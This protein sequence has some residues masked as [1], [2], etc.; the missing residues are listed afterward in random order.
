M[1]SAATSSAN[2]WG[3]GW[4]LLSISK[5]LISPLWGGKNAN[6]FSSQSGWKGEPS[7]WLTTPIS[8]WV[9]VLE[10][11]AFSKAEASVPPLL[12]PSWPLN[13]NGTLI[14]C[15]NYPSWATQKP[16]KNMEQNKNESRQ[17]TGIIILGAFLDWFPGTIQHLNSI[18]CVLQCPPAAEQRHNETAGWSGNNVL[19]SIL[20]HDCAY[21]C[22]LR[23]SHLNNKLLLLF[24][25]AE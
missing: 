18:T 9:R 19:H 22:S 8:L 2:I 3:I 10:M 13:F 21:C 12:S 16:E 25:H 6:I 7:E 23:C 5:I 20:L 24:L 14:L 11:P 1:P 15:W 4:A 17:W